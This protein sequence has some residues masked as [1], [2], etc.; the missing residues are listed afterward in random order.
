MS[1][2]LCTIHAFSREISMLPIKSVGQGDDSEILLPSISNPCCLRASLKAN[3]TRREHQERTT[4][5]EFWILFV[6]TFHQSVFGSRCAIIWRILGRI[7]W[8]EKFAYLPAMGGVLCLAQNR[9]SKPVVCPVNFQ[10]PPFPEKKLIV[11]ENYWWSEGC[12][13]LNGEEWESLRIDLMSGW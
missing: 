12:V 4:R 9:I 2:K 6:D 10:L 8:T 3:R 5:L 1:A 7:G 13:G 11:Q